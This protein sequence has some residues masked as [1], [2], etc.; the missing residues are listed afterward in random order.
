[1]LLT[2]FRQMVET[3]PVG[4]VVRVETERLAGIVGV[5]PGP[6]PPTTDRGV[7]VLANVSCDRATPV[8]GAGSGGQKDIL[9]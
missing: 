9:T 3:K 5:G 2:P 1:M 6:P 4:L 7:V 8:P